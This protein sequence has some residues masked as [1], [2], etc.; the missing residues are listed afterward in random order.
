MLNIFC[1]PLKNFSS[2][3]FRILNMITVAD[4]NRSIRANLVN[5]VLGKIPKFKNLELTTFDATDICNLDF[6]PST[7]AKILNGTQRDN[8]RDVRLGYTHYFERMSETTAYSNHI[9][10]SELETREFFDRK[11]EN[12]PLTRQTDL[13][14]TLNDSPLKLSTDSKSNEE[15]NKPEV[16]PD[17]EPSS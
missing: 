14:T 15:R 10:N 17:P 2:F 12:I 6:D 3:K 1:F 9:K 5:S 4:L 16:N 13:V 7:R 11:T 8:L